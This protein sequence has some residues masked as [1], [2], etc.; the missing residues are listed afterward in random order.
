MGIGIVIAG[1]VACIAWQQYKVERDKLRFSFYDRRRKVFESLMDLFVAIGEN[2]KV[3]DEIWRKYH[4]G[5]IEAPF[6]FDSEVSDYIKKVDRTALDLLFACNTL[7]DLPAGE[8]RSRKD[9]KISELLQWFSTEHVHVISKFEKYFKF[10]QKLEGKAMNWKRGFR[11]IALVL[12]VFIA[13]GAAYCSVGTI[14]ENHSY[15]KNTLTAKRY[16]YYDK[17]GYVGFDERDDGLGFVPLHPT[18]S[19]MKIYKTRLEKKYKELFDKHSLTT[20]E[21]FEQRPAISTLLDLE[22]GFWVSLSKSGLIGLCVAV[23]LGG[24][25]IGYAVFWLI[26]KLLEWFVFGFCDNTKDEQK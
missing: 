2:G 12:A 16:D 7:K 13:I 26:Y 10:K 15:A 14:L 22:N 6:L 21:L 18:K 23:G 8:E 25:I 17:Y 1:I 20:E 19:E 3:N 11:R 5:K 4:I 24:A 9:K